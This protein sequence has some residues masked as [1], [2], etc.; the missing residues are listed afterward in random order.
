MQF[1]ILFHLGKI[2]KLYSWHIW[3]ENDTIYSEAGTDVGKKI[4]STKKATPKNEGKLNATT[5]PE[6]ADKEA[7][8][9]WKLKIDKKY[10]L[11]PEDAQEI[12]SYQPQLA[13]NFE[14]RKNKIEYPVSVQIKYNGV[15]CLAFRD[16]E[17]QLILL[18]RGNKIWENLTHIKDELA[19]K[20]P[21]GMIFDGEI[22]I[23]EKYTFQQLMSLIKRFQ[24][25]T[26]ELEYHVYDCISENAL[27]MPWAD[28]QKLLEETF[29]TVNFSN[30]ILIAPT[31]KAN[32]EEEVYQYHQEF[33]N[34]NHEGAIVR[35]L[36]NIYKFNYRSKSILKVK[37]F[38]DAEFMVTSV[39]AGIGKFSTCPIF[40]LITKDSKEFQAIPKVS[41]EEK[42]QMLKNSHD[43][44]GK[45]ATVQYFSLSD[46]NIPIFPVILGFRLKEDL[47]I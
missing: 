3:T 22:F 19:Q 9:M 28:R 23:H 30:K 25:G 45:Y 37:T 18:S 12:Q 6:Q 20:L 36:D 27:N 4:L 2:G 11:T 35:L 33:V 47:P 31:Y 29:K 43:Y 21:S 10:S 7:Q 15:R 40:T 42:E 8:A 17:N 34:N 14:K 1:P 5:A 32:S 39:R 41:H 46:S 16:D 13:D 26:T 44:I 38:L 24:P